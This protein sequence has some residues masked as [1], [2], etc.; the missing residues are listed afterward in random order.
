MSKQVQQDAPAM[1]ANDQQQSKVLYVTVE[2][3]N[4]EGRPVGFRVVDMYHYGTRNWLANHQWWAMHNDHMCEI[5]PATSEEAN[6]YLAKAA[7]AL[8]NKYSTPKGVAVAK[9]EE[10]VAA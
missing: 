8:Q 4:N 1:G 10:A 9:G 6:E 3:F 7:Q 5:K 2:T